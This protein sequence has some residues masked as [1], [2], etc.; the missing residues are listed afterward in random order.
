MLDKNIFEQNTHTTAALRE[1]LE[2]LRRKNA[3]PLENSESFMVPVQAGFIRVFH[4]RPR[5]P[6]GRR[7]V[8]F[9]PG[10]GA[11]PGAFQDFY[12]IIHDRVEC[13]YVETREKGS[14]NLDRSTADLSMDTMA[15]DLQKVLDYVG[16]DAS[17]DFIIFGACWGSSVIL[18]GLRRGILKASPAA[19]LDPMNE[20][21][22]SKWVI[23]YIT[24]I[25][26]V[27]FWG[28]IRSLLKFFLLFGMK[29]KVQKKRDELFID[30]AVPWKWVRAARAVVD[31]HLL[32][33]LRSIRD[34]VL[35]FNGTFDRI[36]DRRRYPEI[37]SEIP[38]GRFFFME[39]S[40]ADREK[41]MGYIVLE[42]SK[43]VGQDVPASLRKH[44]KKLYR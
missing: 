7:P 42:L 33:D 36:H 34:N 32:G 39:S 17:G 4:L 23:R 8:V 3:P 24:P 30:N 12:E 31:F 14:S 5:N 26:P 16:L 1:E 27:G 44:E 29:Q 21:W 15:E 18:H 2:K 25:T 6:E 28:M 22:F 11:V 13:Y 37:A 41:L 40:E 10:W 35:V 20:L 9:V 19:V 38:A 43:S